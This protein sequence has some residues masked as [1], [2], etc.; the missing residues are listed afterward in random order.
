FG[1]LGRGSFFGRRFPGG[2]FA[3]GLFRRRLFGRSLLLRLAASL[4]ALRRLVSEDVVPVA[5]ELGGGACA[6]DG[7]AHRLMTPGNSRVLAPGPHADRRHA[8]RAQWLL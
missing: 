6:Y 3:G 1:A 4:L 8:A 5:P 2:R 7:T